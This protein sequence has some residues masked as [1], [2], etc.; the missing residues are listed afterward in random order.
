MNVP[1]EKELNAY[2]HDEEENDGHQISLEDIVENEEYE[3]EHE[4]DY[5]NLDATTS[6][7]TPSTY[8]K[9][10]F[11]TTYISSSTEPSTTTTT[12]TLR[13]S[14]TTTTWTTEKEKDA[15]TTSTTTANPK[16][17]IPPRVSRVNSAIKTSI[18]A[19]LPRR[20]SAS[21]IKCNDIS[22]NAKCNEIASRY[23][24][25]NSFN[26]TQFLSIR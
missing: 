23:Y 15:T 2:V 3:G 22:A 1:T 16:S 4:V 21:S 13:T 9:N 7:T 8:D 14:T 19:G 17:L 12:S 11:N 10:Q 6:T 24:T 26:Q 5:A 25:T 18:V 20:K